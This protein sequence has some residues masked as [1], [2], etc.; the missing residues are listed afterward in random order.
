MH[1]SRNGSNLISGAASGVFQGKKKKKKERPR[2]LFREFIGGGGEGIFENVTLRIPATR[3]R[4]C[5]TV[6]CKLDN[7]IRFRLN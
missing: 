3:V 7:L 6:V 2:S 4:M 5:K 1:H